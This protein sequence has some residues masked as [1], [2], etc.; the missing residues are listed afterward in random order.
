MYDIVYKFNSSDDIIVE[1]RFIPSSEIPRFG[2]QTKI[3]K[4]FNNIEWFGRG[5]HETMWD[6]KTGGIIG[7][8]TGTTDS[9]IHDYVR[10]QDNGNR[11]DVRW[12]SIVNNDKNGIK[13]SD[14]RGTLLNFSV[15]PYSMQDLEDAKH[16]NDLS[17]RDFNLVN[18][19]Y[20][21]KGAGGDDS[22]GAL[23]HK[24]YRLLGNIE[25]KYSFKITSIQK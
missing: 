13:I 6:R 24:E 10:P 14:Y 18:I 9:L 16:I 4:E 17:R 2:L 8:H 11:T 3:P 7:I 25:Y 21:Q 22:W 20:K 15:W 1:C 5:P 23:V 19:D 12:F